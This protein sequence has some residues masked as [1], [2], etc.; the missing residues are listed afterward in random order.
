METGQK[1]ARRDVYIFV[2][3]RAGCKLGYA[4]SL[5]YCRLLY[6][7]GILLWILELDCGLL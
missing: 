3:E 6:P 4:L 7:T 2:G 5:I 1:R